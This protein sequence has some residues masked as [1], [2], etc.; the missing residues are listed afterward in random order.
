MQIYL[1]LDGPILDVSARYYAIYSDLL[2]REG[3]VPLDQSSYWSLK[4]MSFQE[5][6]IVAHNCPDNFIEDYLVERQNLIEDPAYL[7]LDRLHPGV[8][9]QLQAWSG[10]H[11]LILV[12]LRRNYQSL[13]AQLAYSGIRP[14]LSDVL[15][16]TIG[17]PGWRAKKERI[18]SHMR[19]ASNAFIIGDTEADMLAAHALELPSVA[20]TCGIR[21]RRLLS[22]LAPDLLVKNLGELRLERWPALF[23]GSEL[24]SHLLQAA[25]SH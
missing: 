14:F 15:V 7:A 13:A 16:G 2:Q 9:E 20:V 17:C 8:L 10:S 12:T 22:H 6:A 21:T 3:F 19:D 18:E 24:R 4:R 25:A 11:Q 23:R 5:S 1:D